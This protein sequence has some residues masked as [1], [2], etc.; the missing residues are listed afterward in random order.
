MEEGAPGWDR[1]RDD[2]VDDAVETKSSLSFRLGRGSF[3]FLCLFNL[4]M[5]TFSAIH[6]RQV[7][8]RK[9]TV[10]YKILQSL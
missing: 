10:S 8:T 1:E 9:G 4:D 5:L 2:R 7:N 3:L 6:K